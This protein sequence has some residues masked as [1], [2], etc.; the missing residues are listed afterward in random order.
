MSHNLSDAISHLKSILEQLK[1]ATERVPHLSSQVT[2]T[3]TN[4]NVISNDIRKIVALAEGNPS[5]VIFGKAPPK[6]GIER[7]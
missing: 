1:I 5:Q 3:L 2:D 6:M 4:I 7:K